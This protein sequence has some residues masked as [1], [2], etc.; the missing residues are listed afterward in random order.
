M[1]GLACSKCLV[2]TGYDWSSLVDGPR[3]PPPCDSSACENGGICLP[4]EG[5]IRPPNEGPAPPGTVLCLCQPGFTGPNC[6]TPMSSCAESP[7]HNGANCIEDPSGGT[8][9]YCDCGGTSFRGRQCQVEPGT[10]GP[11]VCQN[12]G[13]CLRQPGGYLCECPSRFGGMRCNKTRNVRSFHCMAGREKLIKDIFVIAPR[14][15]ASSVLL[16][17]TRFFLS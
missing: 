10:C 16:R 4:G 1:I 9:Y 6:G 15:S 2:V 13:T 17:V 11:E 12:G 5:V 3:R 7:C 14:E 8:G